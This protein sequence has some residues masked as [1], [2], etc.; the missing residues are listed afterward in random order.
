MPF[1]RKPSCFILNHIVLVF[2]ICFACCGEE[3][4]NEDNGGEP[5]NVPPGNPITSF[6]ASGSTLY[7]TAV[8]YGVFRSENAGDSWERINR[9]ATTLA[10]S[11]TA[12]YS[13]NGEIERW[14]GKPFVWTKIARAPRVHGRV[15]SI[16]VLVPSGTRLYAGTYSGRLYRIENE[17]QWVLL[18]LDWANEPIKTITLSGK[19]IYVG[20]VRDGIFR[21]LDEGASWT[22]INT[23]LSNPNVEA[24]VVSGT[25]LFAGTW[26][27]IFRSE[28][29]GL[30]WTH[31]GLADKF[32]FSLAVSGTTIYAGTSKKGIFRSAD[33]GL[34]WTHMGLAGSSVTSLAVSGTTIYAVTSL[35]GIFR[36]RDEGR[37]WI[38]INSGLEHVRL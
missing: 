10:I 31:I 18:N 9:P 17:T 6:V 28:N 12:L 23:G 1:R 27:G 38:P 29:E 26:K 35:D 5:K 24:L 15:P 20:T 30:S 22:Q 2:F 25:T 4:N 21:S 13:A 11:E 3:N 34:S 16:Y 36:S 14:E 37:S 8:N 32:V 7:T 33:Q 19:T